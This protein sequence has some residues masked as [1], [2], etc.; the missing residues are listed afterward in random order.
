M[1]CLHY[2][3]DVPY[4]DAGIPVELIALYKY[5]GELPQRLLDECLD[6]VE[7]FFFFFG[8]LNIAITRFRIAGLDAQCQ[9][10]VRVGCKFQRFQ[11]ILFELVHF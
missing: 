10:L 9:E 2:R 8:N 3:F 7:I 4:K 1:E 6:F 11:N 5:L